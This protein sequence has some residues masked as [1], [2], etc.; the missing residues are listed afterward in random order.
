VTRNT[1]LLTCIL[2]GYFS[3]GDMNATISG[4]LTER[5]QVLSNELKCLKVH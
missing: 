1:A 2:E 4:F 5:K 3:S